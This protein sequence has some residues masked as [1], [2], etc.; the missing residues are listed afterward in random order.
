MNRLN[1]ILGTAV[2]LAVAIAMVSAALFFLPLDGSRQSQKHDARS[3]VTKL[4]G[5]SKPP[6]TIHT[7]GEEGDLTKPTDDLIAGQRIIKLGNV[8][9]PELH[10][11]PRDEGTAGDAAVIVCPGGGFSILAWD[12]EGFEVAKWLNS[13]G[14]TVG[15]LKYRVPTNKLDTVW[16]APV[17]DTQRA[18]SLMRELSGEFGVDPD[19]VG[20]LGFSAGAIAAARSGLMPERQYKPIDDIDKNSCFPDFMML[21]YAGGLVRENTKRL[22]SDLIIDAKT[23]P[24]FM[25]HTFDDPVVIDTPLALMA[26][27]K[28]ADVPAELHIYDAGGHGYGLRRVEGF[29]VTTWPERGREWLDRHGWLKT[30]AT[31]KMASKTVSKSASEI[32]SE[33]VSKSEQRAAAKTSPNS[34]PDMTAK[35]EVAQ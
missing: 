1:S 33:T 5:D 16:K 26:A 9:S 19:K 6:G 10:I 24:V 7:R 18:I 32:A 11:F 20:V 3:A 2:V 8:S 12:L 21:V 15:V 28:A 13:I 4:W 14:V 22:K 27:L 17:Q 29:P 23:P 25:I 34:V 30:A 35:T 31:Q